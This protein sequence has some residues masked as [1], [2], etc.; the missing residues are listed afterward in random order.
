MLEKGYAK[1]KVLMIGDSPGDFMAAEESGVLFYPI[2]VNK[3]ID[4]WQQF[5]Q[6]A[7]NKFLGG[8]YG[9]SYQRK[10]IEKFKDNFSKIK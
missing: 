9:G 5:C 4:S 3:E 6:E 8:T 2:L 7:L 10:L 1:N